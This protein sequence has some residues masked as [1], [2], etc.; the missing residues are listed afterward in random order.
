M[1]KPKDL[2]EA[3]EQHNY[4]YM[5]QNL[6]Y[7]AAMDRDGYTPAMRAIEKDD[8]TAFT[9]LY[10]RSKD[11]VN[12]WNFTPLMLAAELDRTRFLEPLLCSCAGKCTAG[13]CRGYPRNSTALLVAAWNGNARA[14]DA[15]FGREAATS[16]FS[17][18]HRAAACLRFGGADPAADGG[19]AVDLVRRSPLHYYVRACGKH[20]DYGDLAARLQ[21][22]G[23]YVGLQDALGL[24]ALM[25][26]VLMGD[27]TLVA[28]LAPLEAGMQS[29]C[30]YG[31]FSRGFTALMLAAH[32]GDVGAMGLLLVELNSRTATGQR[33]SDFL[34]TADPN[35]RA[36]FATERDGR[37]NKPVPTASQLKAQRKLL[38]ND[39]TPAQALKY[40]Q[41]LSEG[42]IVRKKLDRSQEKERQ[43]EDSF[44]Q[45]SQ[46][47]DTQ[48]TLEL[49]AAKDFNTFKLF[50]RDALGKIDQEFAGKTALQ[51]VIILQKL[52]GGEGGTNI[53]EKVAELRHKAM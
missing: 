50:D 11:A 17:A 16:R 41:N 18:A 36:L 15:L 46:H 44:T 14:V 4:G 47:M 26:A 29:G 49:D 23:R 34:R 20:R 32:L 43:Y 48:E 51:K 21:R 13:P 28:A 1:Q 40:T 2:F 53:L 3:V 52:V 22:L 38:R 10:E 8:Y 33:A 37:L 42:A 19:A 27:R 9:V 25:S 5:K 30:P 45:K 24:T 35:V 39:S 6:R 7:A 12:E 31:P